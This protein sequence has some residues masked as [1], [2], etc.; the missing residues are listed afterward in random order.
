[1]YKAFSRV[2]GILIVVILT[3]GTWAFATLPKT[4]EF[5]G[6]KISEDTAKHLKGGCEY[7]P[8]AKL[9]ELKAV[10]SGAKVTPT[11]I[12]GALKDGLDPALVCR[13]TKLIEWAQGRGCVPMIISGFRTYAQQ[14]S[15]VARGRSKAGPGGS[16]HNF[17]LAVDMSN[18]CQGAMQE[19]APQFGLKSGFPGYPNPIHFQCI[20]HSAGAG[21][22]SG[23]RG[24]CNGGMEIAPDPTILSNIPNSSAPLGLGDAFRQNTGLGQQDPPSP[25]I[26]PQYATAQPQQFFQPTQTGQPGQTGQPTTIGTPTGGSTIPTTGEPP[27]SVGDKLLNLAYGTSTIGGP[28]NIATT[29]PIIVT[30]KDATGLPAKSTSTRSKGFYGTTTSP[31]H[32]EETFGT[33]EYEDNGTS[34][35]VASRNWMVR[36]LAELRATLLMILEILRP[37]GIRTIIDAETYEIHDE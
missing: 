21:R 4:V 15:I 11:L 33:S 32:F 28:V 23:C 5:G 31:L 27:P 20:E 6:V 17:G 19:A 29:V 24:S 30:S 18:R 7:D 12:D 37:F 34:S 35:E 25:A 1:M 10:S 8:Y 2:L 26:P 3:S 36:I 22:S 14:A 9:Y 13:L 16:C